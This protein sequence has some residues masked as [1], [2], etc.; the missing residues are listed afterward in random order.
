L[1]RSYN[2][3]LQNISIANTSAT[4]PDIFPKLVESVETVLMKVLQ[5]FGLAELGI[6][7]ENHPHLLY[8]RSFSKCIKGIV[9]ATDI[10][11]RRILEFGENTTTTNTQLGNVAP[12]SEKAGS[13]SD[14]LILKKRLL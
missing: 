6:F 10:C 5:E 9:D 13:S 3:Y 14:Q 8:K 4:K 12:E 7:E 2:G 1:N 11:C